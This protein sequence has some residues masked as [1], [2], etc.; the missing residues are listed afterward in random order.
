MRTTNV[1]IAPAVLAVGAIPPHM[2]PAPA[3]LGPASM[4]LSSSN[5]SLRFARL[6]LV[7]T[8]LVAI[9]GIA[10]VVWASAPDTPGAV[11]PRRIERI[12]VDNGG[13]WVRTG[14]GGACIDVSDL[15]VD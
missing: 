13:Y 2:T 1:P 9:A 6:L 7:F 4:L 3:A 15:P 12:C 11:D 14:S 8:A 10:A 5:M